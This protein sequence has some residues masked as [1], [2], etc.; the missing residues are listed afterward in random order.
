MDLFLTAPLAAAMLFAV[1]FDLKSR[2]IPNLITYPLM[3]YGLAYHVISN[4]F[5]GLGFS[6]TGI[7][8]GIGIFIIPYIL[9]GMGAGDAKLMGGAGALIGAKGVIISGFMSILV[10]FM[11]AIILLVVH[12]K[13]GIS[14]LKRTVVAVKTFLL[15][16]QW[17]YIP[18]ESEEKRP[19]LCYALPIALG[20]LIY[21]YLKATG[22]TL[23]QDLLGIRFSL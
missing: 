16:R 19:T 8:A 14:F 9:G 6:F 5:S 1:F 12:S 20:T 3:L 13:Y 10:G 15:T 2:K 21:I 11:Y 7:V 17:I 23:I 4:G 22:S 18:P